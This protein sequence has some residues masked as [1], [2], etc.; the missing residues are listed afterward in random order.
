[1]VAVVLD[2][3]PVWR[4]DLLQILQK[5]VKLQIFTVRRCLRV[6]SAWSCFPFSNIRNLLCWLMCSYS[7]LSSCVSRICFLL[8]PLECAKGDRYRHTWL[9]WIW[10]VAHAYQN[11]SLNGVMQYCL[12]YNIK[13]LIF[14]VKPRIP[15]NE[16]VHCDIRIT[17]PAHAN[18]VVRP[19]ILI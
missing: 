15:G 17:M 7:F 14:Q 8:K 4:R 3:R 1:M 9:M 19:L 13:T 6:N 10:C 2:P 16:V 11:L 5:R 12:P 18:P